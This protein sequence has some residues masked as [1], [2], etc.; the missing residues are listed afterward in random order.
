[1]PD[2][3][4]LVTCRRLDE[5]SLAPAGR[6]VSTSSSRCRTSTAAS[7][8]PTERD[9]RREPSCV[10]ASAALGYPVDVEVEDFVDP[11]D[12]EAPGHGAGHAVRA[13]PPLLP[14]RPVP[15]RATSS[16]GRP[17]WCSP[18]P[19]RC[20]A[21]ACRWCSCRASSPPSGSTREWQRAGDD[22]ATG[23]R[24]TSRYARCRR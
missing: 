10:G 9:A 5:P 21:S 6:H 16:G 2:P 23:R 20:P 14:D 4:I 24:S 18:A 22:A 8:G 7:T 17:G 15:A 13:R 19:A 3:S 1:M 11:L 12:W